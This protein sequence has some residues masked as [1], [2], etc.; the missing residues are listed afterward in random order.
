MNPEDMVG[1]EMGAERQITIKSPTCFKLLTRD[2]VE[3][4]R[5]ELMSKKQMR[6]WVPK[7]KVAAMQDE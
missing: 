6:R 3:R 5:P 7:D 4:W 2:G 1:N